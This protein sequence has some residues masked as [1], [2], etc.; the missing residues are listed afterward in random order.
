MV[1]TS[2]LDTHI[3]ANKRK[4]ELFEKAQDIALARLLAEVK[5]TMRSAAERLS[6]GDKESCTERSGQKIQPCGSS[7]EASSTKTGGCRYD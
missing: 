4:V 7:Q 1:V 3:E 5:W 2:F 6:D